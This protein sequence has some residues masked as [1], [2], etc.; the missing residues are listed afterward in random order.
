[1]T[2]DKKINIQKLQKIFAGC[3]VKFVFVEW[4]EKVPV[5][6]IT[7]KY[8]WTPLIQISDRWK[9]HDIFFF[10]LLHEIW[11]VLLHLSSKD[12]IFVDLQEK[13]T[14]QIEQEADAF[15]EKY[16][17]DGVDISIKA[18]MLGHQTWRWWTVSRY[19]KKLEVEK[20]AFSIVNSL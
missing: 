3:G 20:K 7:R 1:M 10:T 8:K 16:L 4:F 6:W 12:D 17:S 13:W 15:A 19:R 9:K 2:F 11:H 5:V 14:S 18:G